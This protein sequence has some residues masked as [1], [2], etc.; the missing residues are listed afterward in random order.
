MTE[1]TLY[2]LTEQLSNHVRKSGVLEKI[3]KDI[4][5]AELA[6][7]ADES[8]WPILD[9]HDID[10][11]LWTM[12]N[13]AGAYYR[14]EPSR[15]GE[16][17][18]EMLKG[19]SGPVLTDDF[20]GYNRLKRETDCVLCHCWSLARRNFYTGQAQACFQGE[21]AHVPSHVRI[22]LTPDAIRVRT[23]YMHFYVLCRAHYENRL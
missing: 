16:I 1:K 23:S 20:K 11:Y 19:Y 21:F 12:C 18:V 4:F 7:H 3:R 10:G 8:P 13:M 14:F 22:Y 5:E 6:V 2:G 9:D 17:I 15:S